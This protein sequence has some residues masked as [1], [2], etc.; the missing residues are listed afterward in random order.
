[1]KNEWKDNPGYR[2]VANGVRIDVIYRDGEENIG[3]K[4]GDYGA[5]G[6]HPKRNVLNWHDT[7]DHTCIIKWR[8]HVQGSDDTITEEQAWTLAGDLLNRIKE[9]SKQPQTV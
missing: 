6:S 8:P 7:R 1:M 2:P 3:V 5:T 9:S 4:T